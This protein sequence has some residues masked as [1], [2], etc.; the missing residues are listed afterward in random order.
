M[1]NNTCKDEKLDSKLINYTLIVGIGKLCLRLVAFIIMKLTLRI[2]NKVKNINERILKKINKNDA[3]LDELKTKIMKIK[4]IIGQGYIE[5][6]YVKFKNSKYSKIYKI[7]NN[8][9][10]KLTSIYLISYVLYS[11]YTVST[12]AKIVEFRLEIYTIRNICIIYNIYKII[13]DLFIKNIHIKNTFEI[14]KYI[15]K[16]AD[17]KYKKNEITNKITN[18]SLKSFISQSRS[19]C[20]YR[21][22]IIVLLK[23]AIILVTVGTVTSQIKIHY[24]HKLEHIIEYFNTVFNND[25]V[26]SNIALILQLTFLRL[27]SNSYCINDKLKINSKLEFNLEQ[28]PPDLYTAS[29]NKLS[30]E[31]RLSNYNTKSIININNKMNKKNKNIKDKNRYMSKKEGYRTNTSTIAAESVE[32]EATIGISEQKKRRRGRPPAN[33]MRELIET[34]K[35]RETIE[36]VIQKGDCNR[37]PQKQE[38][39]V[40]KTQA[41][42]ARPPKKTK[43]QL[44][45][46]VKQTKTN[47]S[48]KKDI[49]NYES[50]DEIDHDYKKKYIDAIKRLHSVMSNINKLDEETVDVTPNCYENIDSELIYKIINHPKSSDQTRHLLERI[51][52]KIQANSAIEDAEKKAYVIICTEYQAYIN[53]HLKQIH[54]LKEAIE[55]NVPCELDVKWLLKTISESGESIDDSNT[56]T[57]IYEIDKK[58]KLFKRTKAILNDIK[59]MIEDEQ[60]K[61]TDKI[62]SYLIKLNSNEMLNDDELTEYYQ[63]KKVFE[64]KKN[65]AVILWLFQE[66]IEEWELTEEDEMVI[67]QLNEK[68]LSDTNLDANEIKE[69][70]QLMALYIDSVESELEQYDWD[71]D[72]FDLTES[73]KMKRINNANRE[74]R[75]KLIID[76]YENL[77]KIL[78]D[79]E[80]Y[81]RKFPREFYTVYL[82]GKTLSTINNNF[83]ERKKKIYEHKKVAEPES[84]ELIKINKE[85]YVGKF[86][87]EYAADEVDTKKRMIRI[88]VDNYDDYVK[89]LTPWS[90]E[91]FGGEVIATM[92]PISELKVQMDVEIDINIDE[93]KDE[94]EEKYGLCNIK[95][96]YKSIPNRYKKND[97][98]A[99]LLLIPTRMVVA[100]ALTIGQYV[101]AIK[102]KV[103]INQTKR[104]VKFQVD[105]ARCCPRCPSINHAFC[106]NEQEFCHR[107][108]NNGHRQAKCSNEIRCIR[109][110][111]AHYCSS[112]EC[113]QIRDLTY[114]KNDYVISVLLGTK[115]IKNKSEVLDIKYATEA[116]V[117]EIR[118]E[119]LDN[120]G[121]NNSLTNIELAKLKEELKFEIKSMKDD[122]EEN[123]NKLIRYELANEQLKEEITKLGN[124]Y[125]ELK[126]QVATRFQ[127]VEDEVA[128]VKN[129]VLA[130]DNKVDLTK[131]ELMEHQTRSVETVTKNIT[132][133]MTELFAKQLLEIRSEPKNAARM[134]PK[135]GRR[136]LLTK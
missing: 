7:I 91:I 20:Y 8:A 54:I 59:C 21:N 27:L 127:N 65:K 81:E 72:E 92:A 32:K 120:D 42:S 5:R 3:E 19:K 47:V 48:K 126:T 49:L 4:D 102:N 53:K 70:D 41:A 76:H 97:S 2:I 52:T 12:S 18:I 128:A 109:C 44:S 96:I 75:T 64:L 94:I 125:N 69:L 6:K 22:D 73:P 78:E 14:I 99:E 28:N 82:E 129:T 90:E 101:N 43:I 11:I 83:E 88:R 67:N 13:Y 111:R 136:N 16:I 55:Y 100:E 36:C 45:E 107:C 51:L 63:C 135:S 38:T 50:D 9:R 35:V 124:N 86:K 93:E 122:I 29:S 118:N 134:I 132:D 15:L 113:K 114:K 37:T 10:N 133:T 103:Y 123:K 31:F 61:N 74:E 104:S 130:I 105:H 71:C 89:L 56:L 23:I 95:R 84:C 66:L 77:K 131:K 98:D 58:T 106:R 33:N 85:E 116:T 24:A 34:D 121:Q 57:I 1:K 108:G 30:E 79:N 25:W 117:K 39:I 110:H 60:F 87:D 62:A 112:E 80:D 26:H 68:V 119:T 46:I 17:L 40:K 115:L